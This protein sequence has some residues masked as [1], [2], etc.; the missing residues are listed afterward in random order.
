VADYFTTAELRAEE[1]DL[2]DAERYTDALVTRAR[3]L[4]EQSFE[5]AAGVAFVSR[6]EAGEVL[7][8]PGAP[9][10]F[11]ARNRVRSVTSATDSGVVL[12]LAS[13]RPFA[14][15]GLYRPEGWPAG[16]SN[17]VLTYEH[18]YDPPPKRVRAAVMTLTKLRLIEG[19]TD[20][21]V[22]RQSTGER[23]TIYA[24]PGRYGTF[25]IPEV[26]AALEQYGFSGAGI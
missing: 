4:A 20:E 22:L 14:L 23:E 10:L 13:V 1:T 16:V 11:V 18:G 5:D 21:R 9:Y 12:A 8:G 17:L 19:P 24:R 15:R 25:G 2:A 3:E 6:V 7:S 26:D